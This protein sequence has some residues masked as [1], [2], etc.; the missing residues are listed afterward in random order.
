MSLS[1]HPMSLDAIIRTAMLTG[2]RCVGERSQADADVGCIGD[3]VDLQL[4]EGPMKAEGEVAR[5]IERYG[6]V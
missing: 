5:F 4:G 6:V 1:P 2:L 3:V